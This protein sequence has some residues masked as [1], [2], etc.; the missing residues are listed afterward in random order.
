MHVAKREEKEERGENVR[1]T[2]SSKA[3][4]AETYTA[5]HY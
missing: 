3:K 5:T 2:T 1:K 4:Q